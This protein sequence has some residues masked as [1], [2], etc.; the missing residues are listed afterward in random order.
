MRDAAGTDWLLDALV[1]E[2]VRRKSVELVWFFD[3]SHRAGVGQLTAATPLDEK[4]IADALDGDYRLRSGM[5][6]DNGNVVRFL[7]Q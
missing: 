1:G 5:K 4:A 6:T 2:L 7:K 3:G